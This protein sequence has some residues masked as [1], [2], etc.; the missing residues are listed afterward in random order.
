MALEKSPEWPTLT[1]NY[2]EGRTVAFFCYGNE[3]G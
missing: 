2:L 3:L 1:R